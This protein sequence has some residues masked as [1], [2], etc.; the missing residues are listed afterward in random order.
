LKLD[1]LPAARWRAER[2]AEALVTPSSVQ[3]VAS[4]TPVIV[5]PNDASASVRELGANLESD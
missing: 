1:A 4:T 2:L 5:H 3:L